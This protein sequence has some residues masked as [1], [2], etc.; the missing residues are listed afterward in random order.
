MNA[1]LSRQAA[2][3]QFTSIPDAYQ[4]AAAAALCVPPS[5]LVPPSV[6]GAAVA[7]P[8]SFAPTAAHSTSVPYASFAATAAGSGSGSSSSN[9]KHQLTVQLQSAG[10]FPPPQQYVPVAFQLPPPTTSHHHQTST[11]SANCSRPGQLNPP[12]NLLQDGWSAA[13]FDMERAQRAALA[14]MHHQQQQQMMPP[15]PEEAAWYRSLVS[16]PSRVVKQ[17]HQQPQHHHH[18]SPARSRGG[19]QHHSSHSRQGCHACPSSVLSSNN[20]NNP[21]LADVITRQ[22]LQVVTLDDTPSPAVS[23][24]TISDSSSDGDEHDGEKVVAAKNPVRA[25]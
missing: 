21:S 20:N 22:H 13:S 17:Q 14:V 15:S 9:S 6:G 4:V 25:Y 18:Q 3:I 10:L 19:K 5:F 2:G 23:V 12:P 24:I 16:V 11:A 1:G 7:V 8:T